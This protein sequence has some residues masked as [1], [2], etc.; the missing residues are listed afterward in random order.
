[1]GSIKIQYPVSR[2]L[3]GKGPKILHK[4]PPRVVLLSGANVEVH[5]ADRCRSAYDLQRRIAEKYKIA[6]IR[7]HIMHDGN[8]LKNED[9]LMSSGEYVC[10]LDDYS[11][12]PIVVTIY[13]VTDEATDVW[14]ILDVERGEKLWQVQLEHMARPSVTFRIREAFNNF[15]RDAHTRDHS[16]PASLNDLY[17]N[18]PINL[19]VTEDVT[20]NGVGFVRWR[21][22]FYIAGSELILNK[23][24]FLLDDFFEYKAMKMARE[25][26]FNVQLYPHTG[27]YIMNTLDDNENYT[28]FTPNMDLPLR[29]F[30]VKPVVGNQIV[31]L[32]LQPETAEKMSIVITG[33]LLNFRNRLDA[34]GVAGAYFYEDDDE[35]IQRFCRVLKSI[36]VSR[37]AQQEYVLEMIGNGVF[38][39]L[40]L[41]VVIDTEFKQDTYVAAF[42]ELLQK[43]TSLHFIVRD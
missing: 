27:V 4:V 43:R 28:L 23:F 20:P 1:M 33:S 19:V 17:L 16:I 36:D 14:N 30:D 38:K 11:A 6:R 25:K 9:V 41:G 21:A 12:T 5:G 7:I 37:K 2:R 40:A 13:K 24:M 3:T 32:H 22:A 8:E 34:Y 35:N 10:I 15:L 31:M 18:K 29:F 42:I 26:P 39:N